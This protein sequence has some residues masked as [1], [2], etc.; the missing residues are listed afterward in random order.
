MWQDA[1]PAKVVVLEKIRLA[2]T[3]GFSNRFDAVGVVDGMIPEH[4][5]RCAPPAFAVVAGACSISEGMPFARLCSLLGTDKAY[6]ER[7]VWR[8]VEWGGGE[9]VPMFFDGHVEIS[10][11]D[12]GCDSLNA[13]ALQVSVLVGDAEVLRHGLA[14]QLVV[15]FGQI[16]ECLM[17]FHRSVLPGR[18]PPCIPAGTSELGGGSLVAVLV[19]ACL[20]LPAIGLL[21]SE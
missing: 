18:A 4:E 14:F 8:H 2:G 15:A 19:G 5:I 12:S 20:H 3:R 1:S 10:S 21:T 9:R 13:T 6:D 17:D 7:T 16:G 11:T